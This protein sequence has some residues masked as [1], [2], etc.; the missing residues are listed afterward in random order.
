MEI[1]FT[2]NATPVGKGRP[3]VTMHG[4]YTPKKTQEYERYV[5]SCFIRSGAFPAPPDKPLFCVVCGQ[6]P[7][8]ISYTKK[9]R[10]ELPGEYYTKKPDAD[11]ILK[12]ILDAL[13]KVAYADDSQ[14]ATVFCTK[15]YTGTD[16]GCAL[17]MLTD[18]VQTFVSAVV[19]AVGQ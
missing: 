4:T 7:V 15:K 8:P 2:I 10:R 3:R 14:I 17:V 16:N 9:L 6:F 1:K 19:K 18:D 12:A 11:N 13:N 5:E